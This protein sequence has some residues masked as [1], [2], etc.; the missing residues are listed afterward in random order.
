MKLELGPTMSEVTI[1]TEVANY[2]FRGPSNAYT[3][4]ERVL[5]DLEESLLAI[6]AEEMEYETDDDFM[7]ELD[8]TIDS[9]GDEL[10]E[11]GW[12]LATDEDDDE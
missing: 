5:E 4:V 2:T 6:I 12:S 3:A 11:S 8:D 10:R 1:E 7:D 9:Y